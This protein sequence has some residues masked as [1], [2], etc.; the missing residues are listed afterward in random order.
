VGR[1]WVSTAREAEAGCDMGSWTCDVHGLENFVLGRV[2]GK[3]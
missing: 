3:E 2:F 1:E